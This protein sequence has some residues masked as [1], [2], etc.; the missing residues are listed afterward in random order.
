MMKTKRAFTIAEIIIATLVLSGIAMILMPVLLGDTK[1]KVLET[2]LLKDYSMLQQT[3]HSM[4]LLIARGKIS[5][6]ISPANTFFEALKQTS[7]SKS[8]VDLLSY[9]N[10]L[11][12][13]QE[14]LA[15]Q[16]F[17]NANT[18]VLTNNTIYHYYNT[19]G[20]VASDYIIVDVNGKRGPNKAGT[21]IFYFQVDR[22]P[23]DN[24]FSVIPASAPAGQATCDSKGG[25]LDRIGCGGEKIKN[26]NRKKKTVTTTY[27]TSQGDNADGQGYGTNY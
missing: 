8:N 12:K 26:S 7:K 18:L 23:V 19:G 25:V 10:N 6:G 13:S 22:D 16:A 9:Y 27:G 4:S 24:T 15:N 14:L 11:E 2:S 20:N 1:E 21:D 5:Q 17:D 3:A